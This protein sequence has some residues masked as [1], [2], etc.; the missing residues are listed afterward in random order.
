MGR[1]VTVVVTLGVTKNPPRGDN[2]PAIRKRAMG[3]TAAQRVSRDRRRRPTTMTP[4]EFL[5]RL[6]R[7]R[8]ASVTLA[9]MVFAALVVADRVGWLPPRGGELARYDGGRFR[10]LRVIDGD[11][12]DI[13]AADGEYAATRVRLWGIDAPERAWPEQGRQ[14]QPLADEAA[15]FARGLCAGRTVILR[16]ESHQFRDRY[17]R[18]LAYVEL[19][20]GTSLNERMLIEGLATA[21]PRF[22][23][24]HVQRY[25]LLEKQARYE[26]R[27]LWGR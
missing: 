16:L 11:T 18:L 4:E 7:R 3:R 9:V 22:P 25:A 1:N 2:T 13:D 17:G 27:G 8:R 15:V 19:A 24:R 23:H 6:R 26:K 21:D 5:H 14:A 10:V 20:D 12:L